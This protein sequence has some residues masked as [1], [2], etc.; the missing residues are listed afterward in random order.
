[1]KIKLDPGARMPQYAHPYDAGMDLFANERAVLRPNDW[2]VVDT[3]THIA[4]PKHYFGLVTSK[5]GLMARSGITCRGTIDHGYTGSIKAVLFNHSGKTYIVE[6]G[7]K[8]TQL[9][10]MRCEHP[11]LELVDELEDTDRG[12]NGFGSTGR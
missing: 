4:I 10:I 9:I 7:D 5:S 1:M 6:K 12:D 8:V 2:A 3:G 11:N